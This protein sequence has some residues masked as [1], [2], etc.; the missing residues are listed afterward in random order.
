[1]VGKPTT[2]VGFGTG[3]LLRIGSARARQDILAAAYSSGIR[4]FDTAPIY[5]LGESERALG[6]FLRGRRALVTLTTK[7][8][9]RPSP[10]AA[11]LAILQGVGRR[12]LQLFPALRRTAVRNSGTLYTAPTFSAAAVQASLESSLRALQTDYVDFFLAHQASAAAMPGADLIELLERLR[13][14]GKVLAYGVATEFSWLDPVLKR[15]PQLARVVQFDSD[16]GG[17]HARALAQDSQRLLITYGLLGRTLMTLRERRR[18][19]PG[20]SLEQIDDDTLGGLLLRAAVLA[21]P[22]GIVLMQSRSIRR[23]ERNVRAAASDADDAQ[24]QRVLALLGYPG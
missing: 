23:I 11:R 20:D 14:D 24:V 5:G 4:H 17:D 8:G 13:R 2:R 7:F 12:A 16:P 3:G 9:L 6:R 1:M 19:A 21:N 10:L 18:A 15:C 22:D